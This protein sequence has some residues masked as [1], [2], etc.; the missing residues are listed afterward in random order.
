MPLKASFSHI[1][2]FSYIYFFSKPA[3]PFTHL[4]S[5]NKQ[6]NVEGEGFNFKVNICLQGA[7]DIYYLFEEKGWRSLWLVNSEHISLEC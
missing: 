7:F 3:N 4:R 5:L 6:G 2:F 1:L